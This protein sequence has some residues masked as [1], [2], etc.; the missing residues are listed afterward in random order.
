MEPE[1]QQ[2][3]K[4]KRM[5]EVVLTKEPKV[6]SIAVREMR[7][8]VKKLKRGIIKKKSDRTSGN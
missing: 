5:V 8:E 6:Q 4:L 7:E 2:P 3:E 1:Y